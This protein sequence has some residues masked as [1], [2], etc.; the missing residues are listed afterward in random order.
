MNNNYATA[1]H[2]GG[3]S[4]AVASKIEY[5]RISVANFKHSLQ[6]FHV[7]DQVLPGLCSEDEYCLK[8][9]DFG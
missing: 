1:R 2:L 9:L 3:L 5:G 6:T 7:C 8:K 4:L